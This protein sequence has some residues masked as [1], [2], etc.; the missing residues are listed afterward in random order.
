[1]QRRWHS[2]TAALMCW[3][4]NR[5]ATQLPERGRKRDKKMIGW[6]Y[7]AGA[8][9]RIAHYCTHGAGSQKSSFLFKTRIGRFEGKG[10]LDV[11][12]IVS[13]ENVV[14]SWTP[15]WTLRRAECYRCR[16]PD[17]LTLGSEWGRPQIGGDKLTRTFRTGWNAFW[18]TLIGCGGPSALWLEGG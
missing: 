6:S 15:E 4:A 9:R 17:T 14:I 10:S 8:R 7:L 3:L 16:T 1:M 13:L 11:V 5:E 18:I 2:S 12:P